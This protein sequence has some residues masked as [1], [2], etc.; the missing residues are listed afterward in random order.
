MCE[1]EGCDCDDRFAILPVTEGRTQA[2]TT[3]CYSI[4]DF[5][6]TQWKL[7][8]HT[9]DLTIGGVPVIW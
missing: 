7:S 3:E 9:L 4:S 1:V 8:K 5:L 2:K 6:N